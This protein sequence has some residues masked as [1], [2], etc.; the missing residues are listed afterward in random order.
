MGY[1][2]LWQKQTGSLTIS[3][4]EC[5]KLQIQIVKPNN[6]QDATSKARRLL[7]SL[8]VQLLAIR[9]EM[10]ITGQLHYTS[11]D[12]CKPRTKFNAINRSVII[13]GRKFFRRNSDCSIP[14]DPPLILSNLQTA[15]ES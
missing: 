1:R 4:R 14:L 13:I 6:F 3:D 11:T 9:H 2:N 8:L 10:L 15:T 12:M 5:S 7:V